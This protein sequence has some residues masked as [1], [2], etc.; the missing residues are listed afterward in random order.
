[1]PH[2]L[3]DLTEDQKKTILD[4]CTKQD[5]QT[6]TR[7]VFEDP[8]LDGRSIQGITVRTFIASQGFKVKTTGTT[9]D[10]VILTD[11]QKKVVEEIGPRVDNVLE[12]TRIVF[13]NQT[14]KQMSREYRAVWKC[15]KEVYPK[16][17][18]ASEEMVDDQYEPPVTLPML[19]GVVNDCVPNGT[20]KRTYNPSALKTYEERQLR[21]LMGYMRVLRFKYQAN[22]YKHRIDRNLY[23][24][25]FIRFTHEKP[26]LTAEE[27]DQYIS[28]A[29]ETV[30]I[31]Q[32]ERRLQELDAIISEMLG[33]DRETRGQFMPMVELINTT[34]SKLDQSKE[35]LKKLVDGLVGS[36]NERLQYRDQRNSSILNLFDA[37]QRSK[38]K[39]DDL[40]AMGKKEHEQDAREVTKLTDYDEVTALIAGQT[41]EE[42]VG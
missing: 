31:I 11:E 39:R 30:N 9:E 7:R 21:A 40:A 13:N 23:I 32:I 12:L 37:V 29:V 16:G 20:T 10:L 33:G 18:D 5:L 24:S 6:I 17:V 27:Q 22:Q 36:R 41:Y 2:K 3:L 28:A 34:R 26:D 14:L 19:C 25:T 15:F 4:L 8:T 1:M 35:R 42:A 38:E